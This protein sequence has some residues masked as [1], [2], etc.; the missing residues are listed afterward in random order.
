MLKVGG[1]RVQTDSRL[2]CRARKERI[3]GRSDEDYY[4]NNILYTG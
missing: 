2:L 3:T 1:I 4:G